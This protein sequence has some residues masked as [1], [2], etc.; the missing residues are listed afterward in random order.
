LFVA[1][2]KAQFGTEEIDMSATYTFDVFCSLD[3]YAA[4]KGDW[5]GY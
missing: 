3:G 5:G 2:A 1:Q 4:H